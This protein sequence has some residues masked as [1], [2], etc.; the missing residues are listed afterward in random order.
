MNPLFCNPLVI[1]R[2][3]PLDRLQDRRLPRPV[4][5]SQ[6]MRPERRMT[7]RAAQVEMNLLKGPNPL[8]EE[9]TNRHPNT[10]PQFYLPATPAIVRSLQQSRGTYRR[11]CVDLLRRGRW[12]VLGE[13]APPSFERLAGLGGL[14][15]LQYQLLR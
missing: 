10:P 5:P 9:M 15:L 4:H 8:R 3:T 11:G 13:Q 6:D 2:Q 12:S 1:L 14:R 7:V